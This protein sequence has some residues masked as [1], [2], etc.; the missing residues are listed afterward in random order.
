MNPDM[1]PKDPTPLALP[2]G[3]PAP[4]EHVGAKFVQPH[5]I[6]RALLALDEAVALLIASG[7][8]S[9]FAEVYS[10]TTLAHQLQLLRPA[11]GVDDVE[12]EGD[13]DGDIGMGM[14]PPVMLP[15]RIGRRRRIGGFNDGADLNREMIMMAQGFLKTYQDIEKA[16]ASRPTPDVRI[17][18]VTELAELMQLR[19]QLMRDGEVVPTEINT[20][21]NHLLKKIGEPSHDQ[22][23]DQP[24]RDSVLSAEP[25]RGHPPDGAGEQD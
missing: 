19:L 24:Q 20:R 14:A 6:D 22:H 16:K 5:P 23:Q 9:R 2:P 25:L 17:N 15:N 7:K 11:A 12:L 3:P 8:P 18:E 10:L 4:H 1:A 21:I 13:E